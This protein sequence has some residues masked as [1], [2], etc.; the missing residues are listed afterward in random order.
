MADEQPQQF[1]VRLP[2]ESEG[3]VL[4]VVTAMLGGSRMMVQC[5]DDKERVCRIPGRMKNTIWVKEG[6]VV[7]VKPWSIEG[8]KKGDIIWRYNPLQAKWLRE[9]GY[10]K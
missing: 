9:K 1:R 5:K 3:E 4:G 8:D 7:L 2:R 6:D 10:I